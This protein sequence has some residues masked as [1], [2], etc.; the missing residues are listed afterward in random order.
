MFEDSV[1]V[2]L[3]PDRTHRGISGSILRMKDGSLL[4]CHCTETN[5]LKG[6]G[7]LEAQQSQD[8]GRAWGEPFSP[9]PMA[10]NFETIA[11]TLMRLDSGEILLFYTLEVL[12]ARPSNWDDG[13]AT[14]DQ[15]AYV[16]RSSDEGRTWS[17]PV[18]AGH[19]PGTCQSQA[20]KVIRLSSGR[21]VIPITAR[22]PVSNDRCVSLC[23]YSDDQGY[24]WWPS[25]NFVDLGKDTHNEE[26]SVVEL[27]HGRLIMLCR[28][29]SGYLARAYS[30]DDALT[31][32]QPE[33]VP[34]LPEPCAGFHM[35]SDPATGDLLVVFC[36]NPDAPA[37]ARGEKQR[38]VEVGELEIP[39]GRVRAPL[40]AAISA[41]GGQTWGSFRVIT[42][43]PEN[44]HGDYGYPGV[45]WIENGSVALVNFHALD[46]I[47]LA[48]IG[49]DWFYGK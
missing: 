48:R 45:T 16:R 8:D 34:E 4:F 32:S 27:A 11:P 47:R 2:P 38:I 13:T 5:P 7:W 26:P 41:D 21:I 40:T 37:C 3:P 46:G 25:R 22:W 30:E 20:D 36:R 49:V 39:L 15:H 35:V 31:W 33:L 44:V 28:T 17:D 14:L 29:G 42:S 43:D 19:F 18:C 6:E 12:S 9:L 24:S 23:F 10:D 1:V